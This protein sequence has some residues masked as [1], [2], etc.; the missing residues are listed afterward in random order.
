MHHIVYISQAKENMTLT[1]LVVI[2][3]QAR[4]LNAQQQVTGALVYG[5]GQFMQIM[6]GEESVIKD[7]YARIAQDPRHHNVRKLAEGTTA[8]RSF[9]QWS[10]A[11]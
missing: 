1:T 2:L 8:S 11:T 3:M 6:E 4:A 9:A 10:G 5:D 7:L